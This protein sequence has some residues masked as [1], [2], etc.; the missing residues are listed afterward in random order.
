MT[1]GERPALNAKMEPGALT[2]SPAVSR[3][4]TPHRVQRQTPLLHFDGIPRPSTDR[5]LRVLNT[6]PDHGIPNFGRFSRF[7]TGFHYLVKRLKRPE[8]KKIIHTNPL[9][10]LPKWEIFRL[11]LPHQIPLEFPAGVGRSGSFACRPG[12]LQ[13]NLKHSTTTLFSWSVPKTFFRPTPRIFTMFHTCSAGLSSGEYG[14]I[15]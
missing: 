2:R 3:R 12:F 9:R 14:G 10:P 4:S 15:S 5:A 6:T 13:E 7:K 8:R 11:A 1:I